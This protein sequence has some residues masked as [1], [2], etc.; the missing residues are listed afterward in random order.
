MSNIVSTQKV[1]GTTAATS[2]ATFTAPTPGNTLLVAVSIPTANAPITEFFDDQGHVLGT[3]YIQDLASASY[4]SRTVYTFRLSNIV[5]PPSSISV[6]GT[7]GSFAAVCEFQ[8]VSGLATSLPVEQVI[9]TTYSGSVT[10]HTWTYTT[11]NDNDFIF[12]MIITAN[13]RGLSSLSDGFVVWTGDA[14]TS[15]HGASDADSGTAGG[16]STTINFSAATPCRIHAVVYKS[17]P[18]TPTASI[19]DVNVDRTDGTATVPVTLSAPAPVGGVTVNYAT[20]DSTATAPAYY[21]GA[22]GTLTFAEG[23]TTKNVTVSIVP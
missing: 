3:D 10:P 14:A 2:V 8:Q 21:T 11:T 19:G 17:A 23:E 1:T 7:T 18:T 9:D 20:Q 15:F 13:D 16:K 6:K 22:S 4:A 5:N 12:A